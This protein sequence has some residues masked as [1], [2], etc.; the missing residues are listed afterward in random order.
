MDDNRRGLASI[1]DPPTSFIANQTRPCSKPS[2]GFGALG[3]TVTSECGRDALSSVMARHRSRSMFLWSLHHWRWQAAFTGKW[4][5]A[6]VGAEHTRISQKDNRYALTQASPF[7]VNQS[8]STAQGKSK[9]LSIKVTKCSR[10]A[11]CGG[12]SCNDLQYNK[13]LKLLEIFKISCGFTCYAFCKK[14]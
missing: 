11:A 9:S 6:S 1:T 10:S 13:K 7:T 5:E 12:T 3:F 14:G 4:S 8:I 2:S